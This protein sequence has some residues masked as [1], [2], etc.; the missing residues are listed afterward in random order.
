MKT[1]SDGLVKYGCLVCGHTLSGGI[2][3]QCGPV[4]Q[5]KQCGMWLCA[6]SDH[7]AC[8]VSDPTPN[9]KRQGR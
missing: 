6:N 2:C 7:Q 5:C 3:P 8:D 9:D 1:T 4:W